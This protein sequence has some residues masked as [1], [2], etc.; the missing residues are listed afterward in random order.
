MSPV[1]AGCI[2]A[3]AF[4]G[5]S[6]LEIMKRNAVPALVGAVMGMLLLAR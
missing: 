6:P 1:A 4:A 5:V 3:S 2:I